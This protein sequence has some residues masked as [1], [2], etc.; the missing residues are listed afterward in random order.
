MQTPGNEA[1]AAGAV[2]CLCGV[3]GEKVKGQGENVSKFLT[4]FKATRSRHQNQNSVQL[5]F[6]K[7]GLACE[8]TSCAAEWLTLRR[9]PV[10]AIVRLCTAQGVHT[11]SADDSQQKMRN[12]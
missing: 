10:V 5:Q 4:G 9:V 1:G 12:S 11:Q 3:V 7:S 6:S 8:Y 2:V